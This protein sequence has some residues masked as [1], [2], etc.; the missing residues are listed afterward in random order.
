MSEDVQE[1]AAAKTL[2]TVHKFVRGSFR[3]GVLSEV[4][5]FSRDTRAWHVKSNL[6]IGTMQV[7]ADGNRIEC[8]IVDDAKSIDEVSFDVT[9]RSAEYISRAV[10]GMLRGASGLSRS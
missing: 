1:P 5:P 3:P 8:K 4:Q 10:V 2:A 6:M 9:F 7:T